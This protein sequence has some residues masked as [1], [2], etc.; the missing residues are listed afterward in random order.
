[1][2]QIQRCWTANCKLSLTL[3]FAQNFAFYRL[4]VYIYYFGTIEVNNN[5]CEE[6]LVNR[7]FLELYSLLVGIFFNQQSEYKVFYKLMCWL[8]ASLL[9]D[10]LA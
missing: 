5:L 7:I 1:V 8:A 4:H 9:V 2:L 6:Y 10:S 3:V